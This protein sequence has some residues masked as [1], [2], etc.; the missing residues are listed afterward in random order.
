MTLNVSVWA[1]TFERRYWSCL[2]SAAFRVKGSRAQ[3]NSCRDGDEEDEPP[4]I[5][6]LSSFPPLRGRNPGPVLHGEES[7]AMLMKTDHETKWN[8]L[9]SPSTR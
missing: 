1:T 9:S 4:W 3:A 6:P 7:V 8:P 2:G 5:K